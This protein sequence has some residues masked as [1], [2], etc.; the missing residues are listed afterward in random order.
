MRLY[1]LHKPHAT[2]CI[3]AQ[4]NGWSLNVAI[5]AQVLL[6]ALTTGIAAATTGK[7]TSVVTSILGGVSTLAASYLA[8][9]RGSGEP[10]RSSGLAKELENF[11]RDCDAFVLDYGH[12]KGDEMAEHVEEYR[13]RFEILMGHNGDQVGDQVEE[14]R[15]L[16]MSSRAASHVGVGGP[17]AAERGRQNGG[18]TRTSSWV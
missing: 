1:I 3:T 13:R 11:V 4:M 9:A 12:R 17:A 16:G 6:G 14:K 8:K 10:E 15:Q 18:M 2:L 5:G 7:T